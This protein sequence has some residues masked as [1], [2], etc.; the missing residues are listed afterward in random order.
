MR[1]IFKIF[2]SIFAI[3]IIVGIASFSLVIF[4]VAGT[5]AIDTHSLPNGAAT[6]KAIV[7][8]DP[9]MSGGAKDI[10]TKIGYNLQEA[11]YDVTLAGVKSS[12]AAN[13]TG[14][15]Y[16]V[17]GGPIYA[18]KPASSIQSYLNSLSPPANA[19]V[20]VFGYGSVQ[21]D[22]TNQTAVEQDVAPLI[23]DNPLV[24]TAVVKVVSGNNVDST[25][26]DFV[27]RLL[28]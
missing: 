3:L 16:I 27:N 9:G 19:K 13:L 26:R 23:A 14:Y 25:C 12:T 11:G 21:V 22:N 6:E 7:V 1:K 10:A 18:G 20:G 2:L 8:Y 17:V 24:L 28:M 4:D 5:F 15:S